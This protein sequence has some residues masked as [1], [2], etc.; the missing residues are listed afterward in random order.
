ML[1]L[2]VHLLPGSDLA[3]HQAAVSIAA[4]PRQYHRQ[5]HAHRLQ[6][7]VCHGLGSRE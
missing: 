5:N 6:S 3:L 7:D 2:I 4:W 1:L